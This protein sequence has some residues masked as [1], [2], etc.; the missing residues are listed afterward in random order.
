MCELMGGVKCLSLLINKS[1]KPY[2]LKDLVS[3]A[4][5]VWNILVQVACM[6]KEKGPRL[7]RP[8]FPHNLI[9]ETFLKLWQIKEGTKNI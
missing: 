3:L 5:S 2:W 7:N 4:T 6:K 9:D 1:L 8:D